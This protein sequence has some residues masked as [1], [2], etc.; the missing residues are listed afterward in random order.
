[1]A[2]TQLPQDFKEFLRLLAEHKVEYLLIGGYAVGMYGYVRN[3]QDIDFWVS[4]EPANVERMTRALGDFGFS[5]PEIPAILSEPKS[6]LRMGN[7]PL[8]LEITTT[9]SGVEFAECYANR[10]EIE[11][12]G[13]KISVIGLNDLKQNKKASGRNKDLADLEN[14][15]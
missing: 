5:D 13:T 8:R 6:I 14:L 10:L 15:P 4:L 3:T 2:M 11:V 1:M 7:P 9:I 12:D